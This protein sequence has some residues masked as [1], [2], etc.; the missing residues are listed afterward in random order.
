MAVEDAHTICDRLE[1]ALRDEVGEAVIGRR[2]GF[3]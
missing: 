1:Q 2:S 3:R